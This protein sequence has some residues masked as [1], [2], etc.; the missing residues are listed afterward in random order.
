MGVAPVHTVNADVCSNRLEGGATLRIQTGQ[1]MTDKRRRE[2]TAL[3][4]D[5]I[6]SIARLL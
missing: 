4:S 1:N 5:L 6:S 2:V 3:E